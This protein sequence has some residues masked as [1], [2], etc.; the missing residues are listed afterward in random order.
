M[1]R[2][3]VTAGLDCSALVGGRATHQRDD[4]IGRH[5]EV[6]VPAQAFDQFLPS[7]PMA[8]T[9]LSLACARMGALSS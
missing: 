8:A 5:L 9:R 6:A 2:S 4:F 3:G 1:H 7:G